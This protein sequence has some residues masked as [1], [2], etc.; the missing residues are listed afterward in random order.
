MYFF[1]C[2]FEHAFNIHIAYIM[3]ISSTLVIVMAITRELIKVIVCIAI[4]PCGFIPSNDN[5]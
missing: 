4:R 1:T 2:I 3:L 5:S